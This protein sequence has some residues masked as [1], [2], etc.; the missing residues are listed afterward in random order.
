MTGPCLNHDATGRK[1]GRVEG[2]ETAC[3]RHE[4]PGEGDQR[5]REAVKG[6]REG[7]RKSRLDY[8]CKRQM[9]GDKLTTTKQNPAPL[10]ATNKVRR[11][12]APVL[13]YYFFSFFFLRKSLV[14]P[15]SRWR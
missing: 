15:T 14:D 1:K 2:G 5:E 4:V 3:A 7:Y 10:P 6:D 9:Q 11:T 12:K 13:T 8:T